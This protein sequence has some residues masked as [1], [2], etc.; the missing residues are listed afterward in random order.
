M[1]P[2]QRKCQRLAELRE[3]VRQANELAEFWRTR[4]R[5]EVAS[6]VCPRCHRKHG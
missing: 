4:Y 6:R 2:T 3:A 5:I 1:T